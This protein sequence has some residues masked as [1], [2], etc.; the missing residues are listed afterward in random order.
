MM[1][2]MISTSFFK[3][4]A[5]LLTAISAWL[6]HP[7]Y[8]KAI[9][10]GGAAGSVKILYL[11]EPFNADHL[12]GRRA[13]FEW[14]LGYAQ[15]HTDVPLQVGEVTV[16]AGKHKLNARLNEKGSW[17]FVLGK[18]RRPRSE[19]AQGPVLS[20]TDFKAAQ[21]EHLSMVAMH[22]GFATRSMRDPGP[23]TGVEFS[24]RI[25]FGDLHRELAVK[26]VFPVEAPE[27]RKKK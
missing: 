1:P 6:A 13:G 7:H 18:L 9:V 24:L 10:V 16:P 25:S 27:P 21:E 8:S 15:L 11:T 22:R 19:A 4:L 14:H 20:A 2:V 26:E 17:D 5:S 3:V 12:K 23:K